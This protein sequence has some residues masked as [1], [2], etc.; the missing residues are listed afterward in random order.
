MTVPSIL[1][2]REGPTQDVLWALD[3]VGRRAPVLAKR[4]RYY[5]GNHDSMLPPGKTLSRNLRDLLEDLSDNLCDDVVDEPVSRLEITNF[6]GKSEGVGQKAWD[7]WERERGAARARATHRDAWGLGDGIVMVQEG[8]DGKAHPYVQSPEQFAVRY[9]RDEPDKIEL[10]AKVWK[11]GKR[12]RLNLYYAP[13]TGQTTGGRIERWSTRGLGVDGAIPQPKAWARLSDGTAEPV[14]EQAWTRLPVFHFPADEVGRYGRSVLTDVIRLQDV[15]NKSC[16]DLVVAM[17]DV[18]LPQRVATGVQVEIDP[19]TGQE[20]PLFRKS[21]SDQMI[22]TGSHEAKFMQFDGAD[23]T[24]FL[25]VQSAYRAEIARKGYLPLHSVSLEQAEYPSGIAL[26]VAEGRQIKRVQT[27]QEWGLEWRAMVAYALGLE[28]VSVEPQDLDVEWA[29]IETRDERALIETLALKKDLGVPSRQLLLEA[30]YDEDD[31]EEWE[32]EREAQA[33]A[34]SG[35]RA[36]VPGAGLPTV[37]QQPPQ[38][39]A[40]APQPAVAVA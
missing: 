38:G 7:W 33:L 5:E 34:I 35:G 29:P 39:P 10:A 31:V 21:S 19:D 12:Y 13:E 36:S 37:R 4:R 11:D 22:R 14:E 23:L 26:L 18:A 32:D 27:G 2:T 24:Q 17:E 20:K 28:G 16:V 25:K 9:A 40:G 1:L 30:G 3:E 6:T 15:L 8:P